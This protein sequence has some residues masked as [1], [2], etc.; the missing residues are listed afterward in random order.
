MNL[1]VDEEFSIGEVARR[2]GVATSTLRFYDERGLIT[3]E[4][5]AGNQRR[6]SRSVLRRV[7]VI[8]AAQSVGLTL[9]SIKAQLGV[10]PE[11]GA[12]TRGDWELL[13]RSWQVDLDDQIARLEALR[14]ELTGCIGCGCLSLATCGLFNPD[15]QA[16]ARGAGPRYLLGDA[17]F[18]A[19]L[20]DGAGASD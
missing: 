2:S 20:E 11:A 5:T 19:S 4:R 18:A 10:L 14:D 6:F 1:A 17:P 12:P 15:D 8:R 3:S 13:A 9:E 16:G 7:A